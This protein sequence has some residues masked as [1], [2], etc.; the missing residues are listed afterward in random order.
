[1][2]AEI[3]TVILIL[4]A[5][6]RAGTPLV[7]AALGELVVE[8]AGVLNLGL[9]GMMLTGAVVGF[10]AAL[11]TASAWLGMVC[12]MLAAVSLALIFAFI[13]LTLQAN[14]VATGLAL[15]IFGIGLSAFIGL[16]FVGSPVAGLKALAIPGISDLPVIGPLFFRHDPMVYLSLLLFAAVSVFLYRTKAGL[17]LR[18]VGEAPDAAHAIGYRVIAIRYLAL[19]F[20]GAMS[21]LAGAYLSLVYTP[22]WVEN[23]SAGRGW[24]ALALVVFATWK[25]GRVLLG[26]YLFGGVTIAQLH[27]QGAGFGLSSHLLSTLPYLVTILVLVLI[28]RDEIKI[29]L[30]APVSL[31]KAYHPEA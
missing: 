11:L 8:K 31:G 1:M 3:D 13:A 17:V 15:S 22:L 14:Q 7:F 30:N 18:A 5:T 25:P 23:M 20:G 29:R 24:I 6:L 9:E 21:G 19:I 4:V 16:D 26:A 2:G 28:S 10:V 12:A 27:L